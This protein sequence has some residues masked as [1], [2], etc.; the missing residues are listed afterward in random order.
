MS[1][2][3]VRRGVHRS[4]RDGRVLNE[5]SGLRPREDTHDLDLRG[6]LDNVVG[7]GGQTARVGSEPDAL[8]RGG[9][10]PHLGEHLLACERQLHRPAGDEPGG[11]QGKDH[12]RVGIHL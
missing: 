5:V 2:A 6:L 11:H 12:V 7:D 4:G 10:V 9:P 3:P 8:D 1:R